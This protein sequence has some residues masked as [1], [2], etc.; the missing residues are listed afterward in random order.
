MYVYATGL[1][2]SDD[3]VRAAVALRLGCSVCVTHTL[4]AVDR[5]WIRTAFMAWFVNKHQAE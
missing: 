1:T 3:A 2:L 5:R 4:A